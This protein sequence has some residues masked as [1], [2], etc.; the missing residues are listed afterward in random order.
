ML[1]LPLAV[2]GGQRVQRPLG[3]GMTDRE[4][5]VEQREGTMVYKSCKPHGRCT[6]HIYASLQGFRVGAWLG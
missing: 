3:E 4:G 2:I 1:V 5:S 6:E